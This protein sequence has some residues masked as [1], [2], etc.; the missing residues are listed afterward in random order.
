[1]K[2]SARARAQTGTDRRRY[3]KYYEAFGLATLVRRTT[4]AN[5]AGK[6]N[7]MGAHFARRYY[8]AAADD[9]RAVNPTE[10]SQMVM[11]SQ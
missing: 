11:M 4:V 1:M 6:M 3:R 10:N 8:L 5:I 7:A 2:R 9:C